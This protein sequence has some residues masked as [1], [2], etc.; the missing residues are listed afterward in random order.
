VTDRC[1]VCEPSIGSPKH[2][3]IRSRRLDDPAAEAALEHAQRLDLCIAS[4][5]LLSLKRK[6]ETSAAMRAIPQ[7]GNGGVFRTVR[8][9][10]HQ[11]SLLHG[12]SP[13]SSNWLAH[14]PLDPATKRFGRPGSTVGH[15][16]AFESEHFRVRCDLNACTAGN[17]VVA[18][19]NQ[20]ESSHRR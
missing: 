8:D 16:L 20:S 4:Q 7:P 13:D 3:Q 10:S 18:T 14:P 6:S 17:F 11:P 12:G 5:R 19:R 9:E 2:V 15:H 1:N